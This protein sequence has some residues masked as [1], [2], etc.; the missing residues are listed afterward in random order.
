MMIKIFVY[1]TLRKGEVNAHLLKGATCIAEQCWTNGLL[2]DTG[3]GF[4]AMKQ[5]QTS[6]IYGELYSVS[7]S[8][9]K[10]L[11]QLEGYTV[12][13]TNNLYER[14][15]QTVYTDKGHSIAYIY[16]ASHVNVGK[17]II[18]NGDWKEH[19]LL[20]MQNDSVLYFAYGS[21]MDQKRIR[22]AGFGHYF[23]NMRGVGILTNYTL[24]FTRKST[25]DGMG[26]ADIVEEGGR[27]EGKVYEIPVKVLKEYL[28]GRE[29]A[30]KAYRPTFVT[31]ECNG[32]KVQA[33]TFVVTNKM[34]ES[35]PPQWY[36]DEI[37]RGA[38]GYLN[39]DYISKIK[40]HMKNLEK[41]N[42]IMGGM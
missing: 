32:K 29:G 22:E 1:G 27:V 7:A 13:G 10:R 15:E 11:D 39:E 16:V 26:R 41:S 17:R 28:Y 33:L 8:T 25:E 3:C 37:L 20:L 42:R 5:S 34:E 14:I 2:Y 21:C 31:I 40:S 9:L 4:P 38:K 24:R 18:P 23:R 36:Q 19:N 12:G 35:A 30:P 6:R